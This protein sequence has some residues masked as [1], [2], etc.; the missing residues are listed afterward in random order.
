MNGAADATIVIATRNRRERLLRTLSHLE[1]LDDVARI[2]VVDNGSSDGTPISVR[3]AFPTIDVVELGRN[4]GAYA[5]TVGVH[6][7][8][9]SYVAFCDDDSWWKPGAVAAAVRVMER[10]PCIALVNGRLTVNGDE[11]L[12][13]A[14]AA[15]CAD[16]PPDDLP[17]HPICFFLAG[18]SIA[19]RNAFLACGGYERRFFIGAEETLLAL[20]LQARGWVLRYLPD[21]AVRHDPSAL[22][23][24]DAARRTFVERNRLWVAWMRYT[25]RC[26]VRDTLRSVRRAFGDEVVRAA[27]S[28]A[29]RGAPWALARRAR[30]DEALQRRIDALGASLR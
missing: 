13:D 23:R 20:D 16:T 24:D 19:R 25:P 15:M 9:T 21:A 3:A 8:T 10:Y 5:R 29:L 11:R 27:L 4:E 22:G 7:A 12:D 26:A 2:V 1:A 18:A 17:G 6:A 28:Q 14:C 30:I